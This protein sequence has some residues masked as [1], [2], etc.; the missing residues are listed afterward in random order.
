MARTFATLAF[1]AVFSAA[2]PNPIKRTQE[3][4][5][6]PD[7]KTI[8]FTWQG[9]LWSV[10]ATGGTAVRLTVHPAADRYPVFTPDGKHIVFS[11]NRFGSLDV[12]AMRVDGGGIRRITFD[13]GSEVPT[14]VSPDGK[15]VL[16][17]TSAFGAGRTD[18]FRVPFEGGEMLRLTD[19]PFEGE[20]SG[21]FTPD[22]AH[23]VYNR[24]A[25]GPRAWEKKSVKSSA[26]PDL[27]IARNTVPLSD[28][29][30]LRR[31]E[32]TELVPQIAPNGSVIFVGNHE[33]EPNLYR[34]GLSGGNPTRL[35]NH[36]DG[37][38]RNPSLSRD[39]KTVAY[40]FNSELYVLDVESRTSRKLSVTVPEDQRTN[41]V[42]D[43]SLTTGLSDYAVSPD[44]KRTVIV[45]R[46]ELFLIPEKGG[47]TRRLTDHV[48]VDDDPAWLDNK[49]IIYSRSNRGKRELYTVDVE[50]NTKPFLTEAADLTHP[51][52]SPDRKKVAFH[53][54]A[55]EIAVVPAGGGEAK[56][57]IKGNFIDGLRGT[58]EFVWSPDSRYLAVAKPTDRGANILLVDVES[59]KETLVARTARGANDLKFLP[60]GKAIAFIANEF[61]VGSDL[62]VVDLVL[63]EPEF[64][65]DELD[66]IDEARPAA[67]REVKVAVYEP[68]IELR[69]RRLTRTGNVSGILPSSDSRTIYATLGGTLNSVNVT[70]GAA[71]PVPGITG[72]VGGMQAGAGNK[73]YFVNAGR[74]AS[75]TPG[76]P[77]VSPIAYNAQMKVNLR[78]EES[79][80]FDEIW[81][82]IDR[83]FYDE[84]F[85]GKNWA[86]I[87]E[88]FAKV[89]PFVYDR[90]DFYSLMGEMMEEL[91]SSHLG[92]TAPPAPSAPGFGSE[93]TAFLGVEFD[94]AE[95]FRSKRYVVSKVYLDTPAANPAS[96]LKVGDRLVSIDG[97]ALG[98]GPI[99]VH[100]A[101]KSG[102]KVK[103][104]IEREG[105]PVDV[106][107]K[108]VSSGARR[109]VLYEDFVAWQR[110]EVDRLSNGTLAYAH[111]EGMNEPSYER[112]LR[113][114]R[115]LTPGKKGLVLDVRYNGGGSTAHKVLGV[116]LKQPW[117][118][119][120]TRGPEGIRLSENIFR[121]DSL[122]LP[123]SMLFNSYSFSNAEIIGEG[124]RQ[125]KLGP[126]IGERTPG[127]VIGTGGVGLWDGG[128]I[129]MPSIGAY[130]VN[131][132]NLENNGRRPDFN[133]PFDPNTWTKGRDVQLEKAV[134]ELLKI[135]GK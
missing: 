59:G 97:K 125:L 132:E 92:A 70:S 64:S 68:G 41:P 58:E 88:K 49:T 119:R 34:I 10:P 77:A 47:A 25:Y 102:A 94:Q 84:T 5:I 28:H 135:V 62:F 114:I 39:G 76:A 17:H 124:F 99:A 35:T 52:P 107:I 18:L 6:S 51:I 83:F 42:A 113:E 56:T 112:F 71:T 27:W 105:K 111:I 89:V 29:R 4:A 20:Y 86:A 134:Q 72:N 128:F 46:G 96:L 82:S 7:G 65:E 79:A 21:T 43:L 63:P 36:S 1:V 12:F 14:A 31:T 106:L 38:V 131:G 66:K 95:L 9:D 118:V 85:H 75:F 23:V 73:I 26:L 126:L 129:R 40:E 13:S 24:G 11:S 54:G 120:T 57:V 45:V 117:L 81:W 123:A 78:D 101:N 33:G 116:M 37:T 110:A 91:D 32:S 74:F 69:M 61:P 98:E 103:L 108:P 22:G 2:F 15:T 3:P 104:G 133:V 122:E 93:S 44:G 53:R 48:A 127:Y 87:K 8:V 90:N 30:V 115:T 16:G 100:L 60:N 50:G 67:N 55:T 121:G 109:G 130:A 80:L 19:H